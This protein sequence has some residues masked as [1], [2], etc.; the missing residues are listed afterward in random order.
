MNSNMKLVMAFLAGG[1]VGFLVATQLN[2]EK[3]AALVE[4]NEYL[5]ED[6]EDLWN[7]AT[8]NEPERAI[9]K[10][11]PE[12]EVEKFAKVADQLGYSSLVGSATDKVNI[13]KRNYHLIR[14]G[15][16]DMYEEEVNPID[17][18]EKDLSG[19]YV[20]SE[21]QFSEE[22]L[23]YDKLSITWYREDNVVCD[24]T[25]EIMEDFG[26]VIGFD[27]LN[28][29][30]T[31]ITHPNTIYVRN[32]AIDIDYEITVN[33]SSYKEIVM[34]FP[35]E[36]EDYYGLTPREKQERRMKKKEMEKEEE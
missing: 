7:K 25:E 16:N 32:D 5:K 18:E 35:V 8:K 21:E 14:G 34:G 29:R 15:S 2:K 31:H 6:F 20:I 36:D 11:I 23:H 30:H 26:H 27:N 4:D 33:Q 1:A 22:N 3:Y 17:Q 13:A 28:M 24:E 9:G 12:T 19:P 10:I